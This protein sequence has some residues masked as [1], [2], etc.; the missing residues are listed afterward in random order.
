MMLGLAAG[1]KNQ[2]PFMMALNLYESI[3]EKVSVITNAVIHVPPDCRQLRNHLNFHKKTGD[4]TL[5]VG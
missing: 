2:G 1:D 5:S 4:S 3:A